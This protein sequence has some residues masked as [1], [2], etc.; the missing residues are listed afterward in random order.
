MKGPPIDCQES[1]F[2]WNMWIIMIIATRC[3]R[4][5]G[6]TMRGR[7]QGGWPGGHTMPL[8]V[9]GGLPNLD[10]TIT[11][12]HNKNIQTATT[13]QPNVTSHT[14][15][16]CQYHTPISTIYQFQQSTISKNLFT[17][18]ESINNLDSSSLSTLSTLSMSIG[19]MV[20]SIPQSMI[21]DIVSS[22]KL[23][24]RQ[25][26]FLKRYGRWVLI[27]KHLARHLRIVFASD[28]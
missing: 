4:M 17:R 3:P 18:D 23:H 13:I 1:Q 16:Y 2:L 10:L 6:Q 22:D 11:Y 19:S 14:I 12:P 5:T 9:P 24:Q 20:S 26:L 21:W 15:Q 7:K 28:G 27:L 8:I 25:I